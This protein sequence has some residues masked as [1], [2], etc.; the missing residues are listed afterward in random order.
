MQIITDTGIAPSLCHFFSTNDCKNHSLFLAFTTGEIP[1]AVTGKS[2]KE[3]GELRVDS[4]FGSMISSVRCRFR[5]PFPKSKES[6][7]LSVL[8]RCVDVSEHALLT[9]LSI[10]LPRPKK[11]SQSLLCVP[12]WRRRNI[13]SS[14]ES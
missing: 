7:I 14:K 13:S 2:E 3:R 4:L 6:I 5:S 12:P 9:S 10:Y 1:H 8:S 11:K